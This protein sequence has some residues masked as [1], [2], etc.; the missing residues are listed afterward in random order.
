MA[1]ARREAGAKDCAYSI[2]I[3]TGL[4]VIGEPTHEKPRRSRVV[5]PLRSLNNVGQGSEA[6]ADADEDGHEA[7]NRGHNFFTYAQPCP[8]P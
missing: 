8:A 3:A 2:G 5:Q 1:S 6:D 4:V 7:V